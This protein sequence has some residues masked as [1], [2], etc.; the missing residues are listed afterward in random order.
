[1]K[2]IKT[3]L[4]YIFICCASFSATAQS[5]SVNDSYTAQ[6]LVENVLVN[7]SCVTISNPI[8][9]GDTFTAGK[10]S[11]A[12]FNNQA[13]SFPF[14]EGVLLSTWSSQNSIGP[15][16][17]N[18]GGGGTSWL[19]DADLDKELG[20]K[21]INATF[22][23]FD[24]TPL[25]NFI[26]FDYIFASNEYQDDFPCRFSDGFAFLIKEKGSA[27][28][29]QNL[30]V[31][32]GTSTP[33]SS[34]NI[35]PLIPPF[36]VGGGCPAKNE[37]YFAGYSSATSPTNYSAQTVVMNAQTNVIAGTTYHIKLVIADDSFQYYDSAVFLKA[38]SFSPKIDLGADRLLTTNNP[39]CFGESYT[40]DTKLPVSYSYKWFKDSIE[41]IGET[42]PALTVI[43]TGNYK[44]EITLTP[45][46]CMTT[47]EI[48]VEY[49]PKII[50]NDTTLS[51]CDD[52]ADGITVF[53]LTRA[54]ALVKNNASGL[55]NIVY[56]ESLAD[57]QAQINPIANPTNYQNKTA[58]QIVFADTT[59]PYSCANY[60]E[61][62]LQISNNSIAPQ[63]PITTCDGDTVQDGLYLFDLNSQITPQV[64]T[65]LPTGLIVEYYLNSTDAIAQKNPLPNIFNNT[66]A[67]Q[68]IIYARI[69]NGSDC[70]AITP[71]TLIVSTF[72]PPNF[73]EENAILCN[74]SSINLVVNAGFSSYLWDTGE[75]TNTINV[76]TSGNYSVT[77]TNA[78]GCNATKTFNVSASE[79]ATITGATINDFDG[80]G[81][82]VLIEY[83]GVGNYEFSI[84]GS[85]FQDDPLFNAVAPGDYLVYVR[86]KNGCGLSNPFQIYVLDYPRYFTPNGDGYNDFWEIKNLNLLPKSKITIFDRYGK[87]LKE[88]SST[89]S[90]WNGIFNGYTLPSD[91][92]WFNLTFED[93]RIIKGHFSL[94]R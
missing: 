28:S 75:T 86:D 68:Q 5:I 64:L 50:L 10:N 48:K 81:N 62:Q 4:F 93:G 16:V 90:G 63:N 19:G 17:R 60:A 41:I 89:S 18:Q 9:T 22:L 51:Q 37:N 12:Y 94:K 73:Q 53:D 40:I 6:Q 14:T 59:N 78:N 84:D 85:F 3:I 45:A 52:N 33:V 2:C 23:E 49:A 66:V 61:V 24:F 47:D 27:A 38:G 1:M 35:H 13:G 11:Y 32:P 79:I 71:E 21:T 26:S 25:T 46:T 57:A 69:V 58:N 77:V 55:S 80:N 67:N 92:Y 36:G 20:F 39:I 76:S 56:Y 72:N 30:A 87:L 7:S 82:S 43:D 88:L 8:A 74:G 91:D 34:L 83:T 54:D 42:S 15:F 65:G 29:Y 44:V 31:I 70:Y